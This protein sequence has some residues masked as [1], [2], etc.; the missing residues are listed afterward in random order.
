[1]FPIFLFAT[2]SRVHALKNFTAYANDFVDPDFILSRNFALSTAG[3][4][5]T[6][7]G[8]A[9]QLASQGPWC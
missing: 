8:W 2:V 5:D 1:L 7:I 6:I 4:Q 9:D 3:A